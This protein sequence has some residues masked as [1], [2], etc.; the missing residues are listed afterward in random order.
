VDCSEQAGIKNSAL[1]P[2]PL[3]Q[4]A[5]SDEAPNPKEDFHEKQIDSRAR[6]RNVHPHALGISPSCRGEFNHRTTLYEQR[7]HSE[8]WW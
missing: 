2:S 6:Y 1:N 4:P 3:E 8:G 5:Y 7:S